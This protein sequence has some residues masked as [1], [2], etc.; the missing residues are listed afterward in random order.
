MELTLTSL[1]LCGNRPQPMY[2]TV[3]VMPN[4]PQVP[5]PGQYPDPCPEPCPCQKH[6]SAEPSESLENNVNAPT[7]SWNEDLEVATE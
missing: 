4:F 6:I 3:E 1:K 7:G 2:Y 5:F